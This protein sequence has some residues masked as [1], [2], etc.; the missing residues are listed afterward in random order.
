M[1]RLSLQKFLISLL[2]LQCVALSQA[3]P[4]FSIQAQPS[5]VR[6]ITGEHANFTIEVASINGFDAP[7]ELQVISISPEAP[8]FGWTFSP[9]TIN[10]RPGSPGASGFKIRTSD[11]TAR[12]YTVTVRATSG[13]LSHTTS[14]TFRYETPRDYFTLTSSAPSVQLQLGSSETAEVIVTAKPVGQYNSPVDLALGPFGGGSLNI[15]FEKT[16]LSP[17]ESTRI[18]IGL[19]S[20]AVTGDSI[21]IV[22]T[23]AGGISYTLTL[24]I[25]VPLGLTFWTGEQR[26]LFVPLR[27]KNPAYTSTVESFQPHIDRAVEFYG[28]ASYGK[29]QLKP[30]VLSKWYD[31]PGT[32]SDYT[33]LRI[34]SNDALAAIDADVDLRNYNLYVFLLD[35]WTLSAFGSVPRI[36]YTADGQ[37]VFAAAQIPG[38]AP[39]LITHEMG[40]MFYL[41]DLYDITRQESFFTYWDE[42]GE[43]A[44]LFCGWSR[45]RLGWLPPEKVKDV[46][47]GEKITIPLN[48]IELNDGQTQLIRIP[49]IALPESTGPAYPPYVV[50]FSPQRYFVLEARKRVG[51]DS[52]LPSDG[53]LLYSVD[54]TINSGAG[55]IRLVDRTPATKTLFDGAFS[56]N[57]GDTSTFEDAANGLRLTIVHVSD[58]QY[59]IEIDY[60]P[61]GR[62][63]LAARLESQGALAVRTVGGS[64]AAEAG[65]A[66]GNL[67]TGVAP[68]A[69][70]VISYE[71]NGVVVSEVGVPVSRPTTAARV[72]ID[73]Q[74][75]V[76]TGF[77]AVNRSDLAAT[78]TLNLRDLNGAVISSGV[79]TL[80]KDAHMARFVDQLG[81]VFPGFSVP[82]PSPN[83]NLFGTLELS[84]DQPI[85]IVALRLTVNQR[86]EVLLTTTPVADLTRL[87]AGELI[88]SQFAEGGGYTTDVFLINTSNESQSGIV[89]WHAD[90]GSTARPPRTYSIPAG[91]SDVIQSNGSGTGTRVGWIR[92]TPNAGESTPAGVALFQY[93][94]DGIMVTQTGISAAALTTRARVYVDMTAGHDTGLALV[95]PGATPISVSV[96]A[97][98]LD[99]S[100]IPGATSTV[101]LTI[102][103]HSAKFAREFLPNLPPDFRGMIE[104]SSSSPFAALTLRSL[105]NS[106][107][108]FILTTL[109]VA[110]LLVPA[111]MPILF[112]QIANGG[113]YTTEFILLGTGP[114]ANLA[115]DLMR[116]DG[117]PLPV[118]KP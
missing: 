103:G 92:I 71:Q 13:A 101:P 29:L 58:D 115:L 45:M 39:G 88:F 57:L 75:A 54:E 37:I 105:I 72:F 46:A 63:T 116:S 23:G 77:A 60:S 1:S 73:Y 104:I 55:P 8:G 27:V 43:G 31:L 30:E 14:V 9:G 41:P 82:P 42:M 102:N 76:N 33:G 51:L 68:Y 109:P 110:D 81:S 32:S 83:S 5:E 20:T 38:N 16:R 66:S 18:T 2:L 106:R 40:H 28:Q 22:G 4:D 11:P 70:A 25:R 114:S 95:N 10:P 108:D 86:N 84:S 26:V 53:V 91:G 36:G 61:P 52:M 62:A 47:P 85:S 21:Q 48:P 6:A 59:D 89:R 7:V 74:Q 100:A 56:P 97:L 19:R 44:S 90:D 3:T 69:A 93:S 118:G 15:N 112:P 12:A 49:K 80:A 24:Q 98:G 17:W 107:G 111:P 64:G 99:G 79:G 87:P 113:G 96:A 50:S 35:G 34:I 117:T 67:L 65:F 78:I 94:R